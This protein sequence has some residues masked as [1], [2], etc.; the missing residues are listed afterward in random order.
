MYT[1]EYLHMKGFMS[2][3]DEQVVFTPD[4]YIVH[5]VN[6]FDRGQENN[7]AGK[8][9]PL[10]A[11][12]IALLGACLRQGV[13][14]VDF[15]RDNE[16]QMYLCFRMKHTSG[17]AIEIQRTFFRKTT[18]SQKVSIFKINGESRKEIE[19]VDPNHANNTILEYLDIQKEDLLNYYLIS[20]DK[21]KPFFAAGD[22]LKKQI[23]SR[24][25]NADLVN[26]AIEKSQQN[27]KAIER[28]IHE[29]EVKR[30]GKRGEID[31]IVQQ[32]EKENARDINREREAAVN[33]HEL[34][35]FNSQ[36]NITQ[37]KNQ[38]K[39]TAKS[40]ADIDKR[41]EEVDI[42]LAKGKSVIEELEETVLKNT[43]IINTV[44]ESLN[45]IKNKK[46]Q[47]DRLL[48][49]KVQCPSC[50]FEFSTVDTKTDLKKVAAAVPVLQKLQEEGEEELG[51]INA[52]SR[53]IVSKKRQASELKAEL[54]K[55]RA[56][57]VEQK[58]K[59]E[60]YSTQV[61]GNIEKYEEYIKNQQ[62]A[63]A[64]VN[65]SIESDKDRIKELE[66]QERACKSA[67][68]EIEIEMNSCL[69][70]VEEERQVSFHLERLK[71]ELINKTVKVIE[72]Y[73]N[74]TLNKMGSSLSVNIEGYRQKKGGKGLIEK[75]TTE[76]YREGISVGNFS[77]FS[78]GER[79]R[80]E[81]A[82]IL[83][84]QTLIN[85]SSKSGGLNLLFL[86]EIVE[87]ID[88][89]GITGIVGELNESFDKP[90]FIVTHATYK[91]NYERL[92]TAV[93]DSS[94]VSRLHYVNVRD[95]E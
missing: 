37:A 91:G 86:D 29:I 41:I 77:R 70:E 48:M 75:I 6:E 26:P 63:I 25:S 46:S 95:S 32:I 51:H 74:R 43:E 47:A 56:A 58:Q 20:K 52:T 39:A 76:I 87:S 10:E 36:S 65:K 24:F 28:K 78:S 54:E 40:I 34:N 3:V 9:A 7:G 50:S 45:A 23:I 27:V 88:S 57:L 85:N 66:Q 84:L 17:E 81:I 93:K 21:Y 35:I 53:A 5:G 60:I 16:P 72:F 38:L 55:Q 18:L 73:C 15:I 82:N 44:Q 67:L 2:Y 33:S 8:S 11:L 62:E 61:A 30:E 14:P 19:L 69:D 90:I 89:Q 83:A 42:R 31:I 80:V 92:I 4:T 79:G 22:A 1:P 71:I 94:G 68:E 59:L 12:S 49:N 64:T 13:T